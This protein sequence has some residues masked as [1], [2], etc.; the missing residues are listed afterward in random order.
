VSEIQTIHDH[1]HRLL[2]RVIP[3]ERI[4]CKPTPTGIRTHSTNFK[5]LTFGAQPC[6][7]KRLVGECAS[8][9]QVALCSLGMGYLVHMLV[10]ELGQQYRLKVIRSLLEIWSRV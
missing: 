7:R 5:V 10:N 2:A 3:E 4:P 9:W 6:D 8:Q 1:F